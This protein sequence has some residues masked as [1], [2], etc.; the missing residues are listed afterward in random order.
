MKKL[1]DEM[2][3]YTI[4]GTPEYMAPEMVSAR[5]HTACADIWALGILVYE[6]LHGQTP[7]TVKDDEGLTDKDVTMAVYSKIGRHHKDGLEFL[8]TDISSEAQD[9]VRELL[10]PIAE[11]RLG[12][13]GVVDI[14][15]GGSVIRAHPWFNS[16]DWVLLASKTQPSGQSEQLQKLFE[17]NLA[18]AAA[19]DMPELE[20]YA[21]DTDWLENF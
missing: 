11:M 20:R 1:P 16:V 21:G 5:G 13:Q 10:N 2:R 19:M 4:C 9:F 15:K 17:D 3:T 8:R 7:F 12:G 14:K 18:A 6:M